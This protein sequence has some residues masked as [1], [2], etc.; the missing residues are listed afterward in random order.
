MK[1]NNLLLQIN[2]QIMRIDL[3]SESQKYLGD[4]NKSES[5]EITLLL[6]WHQDYPYNQGSK[7]SIT[8]Y[9]PLQSG[10]IEKGG[11]LET[12]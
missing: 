11:T 8:I 1:S 9:V 6:P 12:P 5:K 4:D 7:K 10:N 3:P 2:D